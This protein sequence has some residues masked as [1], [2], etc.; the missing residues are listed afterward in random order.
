MVT[1]HAHGKCLKGGHLLVWQPP[2][3]V[4]D[5]YCPEH[6]FPLALA[7]LQ[8]AGVPKHELRPQLGARHTTN[9]R[10]LKKELPR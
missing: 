9:G 7:A 3:R 6:N 10:I 5:A 4:S 1:V 8:Q 2:P